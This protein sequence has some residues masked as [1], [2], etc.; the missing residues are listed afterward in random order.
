MKKDVGVQ[1]KKE[2]TILH[3][4]KSDQE[5]TLTPRRIIIHHK[6]P[7]QH[8]RK[9][10][11]IRHRAPVRARKRHRLRRSGDDRARGQQRAQRLEERQEVSRVVRADA[12]ARVAALP[13]VLPVDVDPVE[14]ELLV[15][16]LDVARE[17]EAALRCRGC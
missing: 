13:R 2:P 17:L 14:P 1:G 6:H 16:R 8:V 7:I 9:R 4:R 3:D 11:H 15:E 12:V 5:E 10:R